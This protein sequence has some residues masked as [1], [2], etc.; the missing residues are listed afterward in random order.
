L[1]VLVASPSVLDLVAKSVDEMRLANLFCWAAEFANA[2]LSESA[3]RR[4]I[5]GHLDTFDKKIDCILI[6][7]DLFDT[8]NRKLRNQYT[9]FR[10]DLSRVLN[11]RDV[12]IVPGNHDVR[13]MGIV[14]NNYEFVFDLGF[15]PIV[16]EEEARC[17][18]FPEKPKWM[19]WRTYHR[20]RA[21]GFA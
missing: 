16:V 9:E 11:E 6:T 7:G 19:H 21:H 1:A 5:K 14:G 12:I 20:L 13:K 2:R 4:Y 3:R 17:E 8:P 10:S 18:P 15:R